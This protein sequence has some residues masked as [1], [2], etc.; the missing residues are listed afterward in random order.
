[1]K[2]IFILFILLNFIACTS[3]TRICSSKPKDVFFLDT[4]STKQCRAELESC[5]MENYKQK[6]DFEQC[7]KD[8]TWW[9]EGLKALAVGALGIFSGYLYANKN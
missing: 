5:K 8:N 6:V 7:K 1:M 4:N 2:K 3:S 9:Q